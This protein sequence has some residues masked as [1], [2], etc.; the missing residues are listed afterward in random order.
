MPGWRGWLRK[1][2]ILSDEKAKRIEAIQKR[3]GIS[4]GE[5]LLKDK[6]LDRNGYLKILVTESPYPLATP[7]MLNSVPPGITN[8]L[9]SDL[10]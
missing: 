1:L 7:G 5:A 3:D 8:I 10:A 4:F 2:G 9:S 6:V